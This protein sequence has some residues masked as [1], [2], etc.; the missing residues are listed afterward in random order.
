VKFLFAVALMTGPVVLINWWLAQVT[1]WGLSLFHVDSGI[2]GPLL[3]LSVL[4]ALIISGVSVG[5]S[6]SK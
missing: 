2:G 4:S 5:I 6:A 3:F 1:V